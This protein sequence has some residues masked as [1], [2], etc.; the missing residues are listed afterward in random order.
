MIELIK[1]YFRKE[2]NK[3][4][5]KDFSIEKITDDWFKSHFIYAPDVVYDWIKKHNKK[6]NIS[7]LD[8]GCGDGIMSL[9]LKLRHPINSLCGVDL[10]NSNSFLAETAKT[11]IGLQNLPS[12]LEFITIDPNISLFE[13]VQRRFD[14]VYSWSVFEHIE[15]EFIP[16]ILKEIKE[17]I[18]NQG[19]FFIQIEP[20]YYSPFGSHLGGVIKESWAH[21]LL[22]E[23]ELSKSVYGFDL[24]SMDGEFKNKTFEVC[25]N[26][27]FKKYLMRE[28]KT[29][30]KLTCG[31]LI[32]LCEDA[33][34]SVL[35]CWKNKVNIEP[36]KQLLNIYE[37]EDLVTSEIRIL[38]I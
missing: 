27:D 7:L 38:L 15:I 35:E 1:K 18:A 29:L 8:F 11:Q 9:G 14:Y 17:T 24:E 33:G 20:L 26:D 28:Y 25:S 22:T 34:F 37:R 10:H 3:D 31:Q 12:K 21:L 19:A 36:P 2:I 30:N 4:S 13:S 5:T 23:E 16:K 6:S 32:K